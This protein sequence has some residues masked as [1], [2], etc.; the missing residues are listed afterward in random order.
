M[1][2]FF[3]KGAFPTAGSMISGIY[4]GLRPEPFSTLNS[5]LKEKRRLIIPASVFV[6]EPLNRRVFGA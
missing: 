1:V 4:M 6:F 3:K 5:H 2:G